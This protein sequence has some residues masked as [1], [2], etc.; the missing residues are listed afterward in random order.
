MGKSDG[1]LQTKACICIGCQLYCSSFSPCSCWM[2]G[3]MWKKDTAA[4]P[5]ESGELRLLQ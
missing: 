2:H 3:L 5:L 4:T 1:V